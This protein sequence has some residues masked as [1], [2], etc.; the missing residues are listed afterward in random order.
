MPLPTRLDASRQATHDAHGI[1]RVLRHA[2][3]GLRRRPGP[4]AAPPAGSRPAG[5]GPGDRRPA[6]GPCRID[7]QVAG[8]RR[9]VLVA[10]APG[11]DLALICEEARAACRRSG[12]LLS[13]SDELGRVAA[14]QGCWLELTTDRNPAGQWEVWATVHER[15]AHGGPGADR[16]RSEPPRS[17]GRTDDA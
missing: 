2:W 14:R 1:G 7:W 15:P 6:A 12:S 9:L 8:Y 13:V 3:R 17:R 11:T 16:I 4:P 10:G 5:E